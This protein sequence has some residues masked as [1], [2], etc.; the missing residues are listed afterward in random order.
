MTITLTIILLLCG[1]LAVVQAVNSLSQNPRA[2]VPV[3]I[4]LAVM[5]GLLIGSVWF[6]YEAF[7]R[8]NYVIYGGLALVVLIMLVLAWKFVFG[9]RHG[10]VMSYTIAFGVYAAVVLYVTLFSR[11]M[12]SDASVEE[13]AFRGLELALATHSWEPMQHSLLNLALFLPFG[14]LIPNMN[15]DYLARWGFAV[16][17]GLVTSTVI[18]GVQMIARMGQCDIDDIIFNTVGASLGYLFFM[19]M[20]QVRKNWRLS[21]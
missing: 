5:Y 16:L 18:E 3:T 21:A 14:Y 11:Q 8:S 9:H 12:G 1:F 6:V 19:F 17:G 10:L 4:I 20:R 7:G 2:F 13:K 15:P